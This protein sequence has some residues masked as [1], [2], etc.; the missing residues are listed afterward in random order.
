MGRQNGLLVRLAKSIWFFPLILTIILVILTSLK[1]SGSSIGIYNSFLNGKAEDSNL[2]ANQPRSIRSD[3]WLLSTQMTLAQSNNNFRPI[4]RNIGN[5]Q[6]MAILLD[7]PY[8]EWSVMFKPHN[9]AFFVLP[10][11]NALA[12][13]WWFLGYLLIMS[14]YFF[15]LK[16]LPGRI[17][18]AALLGLSLFFSPFVQWWYLHG[19]LG[20]LY[21]P[22][23]GL[24]CVQQMLVARRY[25]FWFWAALLAYVGTCF[26][27]ILYPPFQ[28]PALVVAL[29]LLAAMLL[30]RWSNANSQLPYQTLVGIV[31]AV[32]V[33]GGIT[34]G[35]LKTHQPAIEASLHTAYPGERVI[36]SGGYDPTHLF[37]G[38][39]SANL[40]DNFRA[41]RYLSG[42]KGITNQSE[43]ANFFLVLPFLM[44]GA[45]CLA[46]RFYRQERRID[47]PLVALSLVFILFLLRLLFP[48]GD[49]VFELLQLQGVPHNR[50]LIGVGLLNFLYVPY[51]IRAIQRLG[52]APLKNTWLY[53]AAVAFFGLQLLIGRRVFTL[54]PGF[55]EM[56][57][58]V[59]FSLAV[60]LVVV[61][62]S[63]ARW[64][65][66]GCAVLFLVTFLSSYKIHPLYRGVS[67]LKDTPII[68]EIRQIGAQSPESRWISEGIYI[69]H[70]VVVAG[71]RSLS[72]VY[73][74][75][76]PQLWQAF[77]RPGEKDIYNRFAHV[78][79]ALDRN[80]ANSIPTH[81]SLG[82]GDSF[83]VLTES[84][85][86]FLADSGVKYYL[87]TIPLSPT[88]RCAEL[89]EQVSYPAVEFYIYELRYL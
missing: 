62:L 28:L 52:G 49:R 8:R 64:A 53:M 31:V 40:Q 7:V 71:V 25:L 29:G 32:L 81:L 39:L 6:D 30:E 87:T 73:T 13:R 16:I 58:V 48:G 43:A 78:N 83:S 69:E 45:I 19:T 18:L 36:L 1:I 84:C 67:I 38:Y 24:V 56:S 51:F 88:D 10:F 74:Y 4:N 17:W 68:Q 61:A 2:L 3:E 41:G 46:Y 44:L 65:I 34:L 23:L 22:L 37:A 70:F 66:V 21:Y 47:W 57:T 77:T 86:Q 60:P 20:S 72:G 12:F 33:A 14:A 11:E 63:R 42:P 50:L 35:Y 5:G 79:F 59:I 9:L 85:S 55:V 82:A 76:Q 27:L 15:I 80:D 26:A 54:F 89:I 75:P